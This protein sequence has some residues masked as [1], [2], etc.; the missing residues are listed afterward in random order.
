[1]RRPN[2]RWRR[3]RIS[4]TPGFRLKP[5]VTKSPP[6][7]LICN[8]SRKTRCRPA[9]RL[10]PSMNERTDAFMAVYRFFNLRRRRFLV[11]FKHG[12]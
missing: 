3:P 11:V 1:M 8:V 9:R 5:P 10:G 4:G 6:V 12:A 7:A 2:I